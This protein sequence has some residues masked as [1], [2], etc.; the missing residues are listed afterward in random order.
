ML[1]SGL[2]RSLVSSLVVL[3]IAS[4]TRTDGERATNL[5]GGI[6][7]S[8]D[9]ELRTVDLGTIAKGTPIRHDFVVYNSSEQPFSV[10]GVKSN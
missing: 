10:K 2:N 9:S 4:C 3:S 1:G 7:P 8:D 6:L 5:Q